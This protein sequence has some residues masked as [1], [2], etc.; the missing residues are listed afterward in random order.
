MAIVLANLSGV[1]AADVILR[2]SLSSRESRGHLD[3][4]MCDTLV[5]AHVQQL[6]QVRIDR[7]QMI[8]SLHRAF[9]ASLLNESLRCS[10]AQLTLAVNRPEL[11]P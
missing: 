7:P 2:L 11:Q 9:G 10:A 6:S 5:Y 4:E 1:Q 3:S 8:S